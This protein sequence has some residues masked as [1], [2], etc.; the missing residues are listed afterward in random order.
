MKWKRLLCLLAMGLFVSLACG[1]CSDDQENAD[2]WRF[3]DNSAPGDAGPGET[4]HVNQT[5]RDTPDGGPSDE[6]V[7]VTP[8]IG[9]CDP[10]CQTGCGR[11]ETCVP[12]TY[13][14]GSPL[15]S[16]CREDGTVPEHS[17]CVGTADSCLHGLGCMIPTG[18]ATS[19]CFSFCVPGGDPG[20][21]E[22]EICQAIVAE[23]PRVGI[24][25]TED[26]TQFP[27]D[28]CPPTQDCYKTPDGLTCMIYDASARLGDSCTA[29][30]QCNEDQ[31]C[32]GS[33]GPTEEGCRAKCVLGDS[34]YCEAAE[35][36][37]PLLNQPYGACLPRL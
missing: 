34:S 17:P 8:A 26:C 7:G 5:N 16:E 23:D 25:I 32:T 28:N 15:R 19:R 10:L 36:C 29:S 14:P 12:F 24:C 18:R 21:E 30:Q 37:K 13:G 3:Q 2:K 1:A 35:A 33:V 9:P 11:Q 27:N 22:G 6:C 20:C 4:G 31:E